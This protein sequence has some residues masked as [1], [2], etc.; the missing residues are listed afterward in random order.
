MWLHRKKGIVETGAQ[1]ENYPS[2]VDAFESAPYPVVGTSGYT[3]MLNSSTLRISED[4]ETFGIAFS[5]SLGTPTGTYD[6]LIEKDGVSYYS[7]SGISTSKSID[8]RSWLGN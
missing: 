1:I 3:Q 2:L 5:L 7:E 8:F 4:A 6:I